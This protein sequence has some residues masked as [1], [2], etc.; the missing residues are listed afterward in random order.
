VFHTVFCASESVPPGK[1]FA[2]WMIETVAFDETPQF[3][4]PFDDLEEGDWSAIGVIYDEAKRPIQF[5]RYTGN[6]CREHVGAAIETL[7]DRGFFGERPDLVERLQGIRQAIVIEFDELLA[8]EDVWE[9]LDIIETRLAR[10]L[11]GMI[12][13]ADE[14]FFDGHNKPLCAFS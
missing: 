7:R 13:N 4:P 2:H 6:E 11:D 8:H 9:F 14:G 3:D 1:L 5:I 12:F 10:E